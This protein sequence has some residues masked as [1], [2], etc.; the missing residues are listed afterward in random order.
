MAPSA[1]P[2]LTIGSALVLFL[3]RGAHAQCVY[4]YVYT[5]VYPFYEEASCPF[6]VAP[7][8][9]SGWERFPDT[10][11]ALPGPFNQGSLN[12]FLNYD[13]PYPVE[14][15]CMYSA[16][17][18]RSFPQK[19]FLATH[20]E[21]GTGFNLW[22]CEDRVYYFC[23][24][25][26]VDRANSPANALELCTGYMRPTGCGDVRCPSYLRRGDG[27]DPVYLPLNAS[28]P[29][30]TYTK[31]EACAEEWVGGCSGH[32]I[33]AAE[34]GAAGD[35]RSI[36]NDFC[37][38]DSGWTGDF[39]ETRDC[40][41]DHYEETISWGQ[42]I[43]QCDNGT[44]I[45]TQQ[46][47]AA[48]ADCP[49]K[50]PSRSCT[51][52]NCGGPNLFD[53]VVQ[54]INNYGPEWVMSNWTELGVCAPT[55]TDCSVGQQVYS[56]F[57]IQYGSGPSPETNKIENCTPSPENCPGPSSE[58]AFTGWYNVGP[59]QPWAGDCS[60]GVQLQARDI[61][62]AG[63]A[64][65]GPY[66]VVRNASCTPDAGCAARMR[67]AAQPTGSWIMSEWADASPCVP[68]SALCNHG[69]KVQQRRVT[70]QG[71]GTQPIAVRQESCTPS[72]CPWAFS[73]V[74]SNGGGSGDNS[75]SPEAK[76]TAS[77]TAAYTALVFATVA[78]VIVM[79][80]A[81]PR[82]YNS[83]CGPLS[84]GRAPRGFV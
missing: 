38:C 21:F 22:R 16:Q 17:V 19:N 47:K 40:P 79:L 30:V 53:F 72:G 11:Q 29:T 83:C 51:P 2:L 26:N 68:T 35:P 18:P 31:E 66:D 61:I 45:G 1:L 3:A 15:V 75:D 73:Q 46:P 71:N 49:P 25:N 10:G 64:V 24:L 6:P 55:S 28:D 56:R 67:A 77:E 80:T 65:G 50:Y 81:W 59:C 9:K 60:Q 12:A 33:C 20:I 8:T 63:P 36:Q 82:V 44:Q 62:S 43:G 34:Y 74:P 32:G 52:T 76:T 4:S 78:M 41:D 54:T 57:A 23:A 7:T 70:R 48:Y 27:Q 14:Q 58:W 84:R 13:S 5:I 37:V 69:F 39:C 42:C